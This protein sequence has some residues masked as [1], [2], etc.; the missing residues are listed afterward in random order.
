MTTAESRYDRGARLLDGLD[1]DGRQRVFNALADVEPAL[2]ERVI[3]WVR[4]CLQP[5]GSRT[6]AAPPVTLRGL[7]AVGGR[8]CS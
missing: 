2:A 4:R 1:G 5:C 6:R 7:T 8:E 3:Q